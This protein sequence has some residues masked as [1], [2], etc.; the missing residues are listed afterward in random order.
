MDGDGFPDVIV[1]DVNSGFPNSGAVWFY[2]GGASGPGTGARTILPR[3]GANWELPL[4]G[5]GDHDGDGYADFLVGIPVVINSVGGKGYVHLY[6]GSPTGPGATPAVTFE[7]SD[8]PGGIGDS[9]GGGGDVNGDG[10]ADIVAGMPLA[11]NLSGTKGA[12]LAWY[13]TCPVRPPNPIPVLY[14]VRQAAD[15]ILVWPDSP[16]DASHGS[17]TVYPVYLSVLFPDQGYLSIGDAPNTASDP[18][19]HV[20]GGAIDSRPPRSSLHFYQVSARNS[21]GDSGDAPN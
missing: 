14:A 5:A 8:L 2:P 19:S 12:A 11:D 10:C 18:E 15:V 17:A 9:M 7:T 13:G 1:G 21:A 20:D 16:V 6:G 4:A 3:L